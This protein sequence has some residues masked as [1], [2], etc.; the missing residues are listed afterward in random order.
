MD[1]WSRRRASSRKCQEFSRA[2]TCRT[3][4]IAKPSPPPVPAA[5]RPTKRR[6]FLKTKGYD[7]EVLK[8]ADGSLYHRGHRGHREDPQRKSKKRSVRVPLCTSVLS[9]VKLLIFT[10]L[11]QGRPSAE[12]CRKSK[13]APRWRCRPPRR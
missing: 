9:V 13:G 8:G 3:A 11:E 2:A 6:N 4:A 1:I 10:L 5:W 7:G 12:S